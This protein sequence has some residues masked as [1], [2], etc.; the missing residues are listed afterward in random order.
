MCKKKM[1]GVSMILLFVGLVCSQFNNLTKNPVIYVNLDL[2]IDPTNM[3]EY[4]GAADHVFIGSITKYVGNY[5]DESNFIPYSKYDVKVI[6]NIKGSLVENV[7]IIKNGGYN[8]S[9]K[10]VM[11]ESNGIEDYFPEV[12]IMY[13]FMAYSQ[14][15][16]SLLLTEVNGNTKYHFE[17]TN[18]SEKQ[19]LIY[20]DYVGNQTT[21]ERKRYISK[22]AR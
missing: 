8:A 3:Y 15:D 13:I 14:P 9:G 10:L 17:N 6:E 21:F 7:Q 12:G 22:Y 2:A 4:V 18:E 19:K 5:N 1:I 16:G 20:Y 11:M